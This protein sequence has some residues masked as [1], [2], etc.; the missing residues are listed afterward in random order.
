MEKFEEY[1]EKI[2]TGLSY[3]KNFM[4]CIHDDLDLRAVVI[5]IYQQIREY[6]QFVHIATLTIFLVVSPLFSVMARMITCKEMIVDNSGELVWRAFYFAEVPNN[7]ISHI[8][9]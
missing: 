9:C 8:H 2:H 5:C 6:K 3:L 1:S 7:D 4:F